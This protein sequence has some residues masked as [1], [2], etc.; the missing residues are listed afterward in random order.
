MFDLLIKNGQVV[1]GSGAN[2]FQADVAVNADKVVHVGGLEIAEAATVID[3]AGQVVTPGFIDVHSHGD[4]TLP[5]C[6]TA[7]SLIHQ[8]VTTAVVGQCGISLAPLLTA[9][10]EEVIAS[11]ETR[12]MPVPWE[13]WSDFRSYLKFMSELGIAVN[14][15]PLVGQGTVRAAVMSFA[16]GRANMNQM[17]GMRAEV[18]KAMEAGAVGIST[19]LVY[20]PGSYAST[21]ELIELVKV[22]GE[23]HGLY[24]SH[25]RGEDHVLLDAVAEALRIGRETGAAVHI[26]HLKAAWPVNWD[27]QG[28]AIEMIEQARRE[29][30]DVSADVYPYLA[31]AT[32]LK[33]VL[34]EWA[35][36]GGKDTIL[37]RL[38]EPDSRKKIIR[39]MSQDGFCRDGSWDLVLISHS[40]SRPDY[41]GRYVS[42]LAA[43]ARRTPEEWIMDALLETD[44]DPGMVLFMIREENLKVLLRHEA[45]MIGSD[46]FTIPAS[47]RLAQGFP[48][49][50]TFGTFPRVL[51][52]Y[53]R[54]E[55]ILTLE[56]AIH[57]MTGSPAAKLRLGDRGQIKTGFKADLVVLDPRIVSDRATYEKPFQYPTGIS[58]VFCNGTAVI[59]EGRPTGALPGRVLGHT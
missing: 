35:Q 33:T 20:P 58:Y 13:R 23:R 41:A 5:A 17:A 24:F 2:A 56:K 50:R 59:S 26:C 7:D 3:A 4:F 42:D 40:K 28:Y 51:G 21:E 38:K 44:L 39:S 55:K 54:E 52:R 46:S 43:E 15:V 8:G 25:I 1:D 48:H 47:G 11:L 31:G 22:A 53:V 37:R 19:G 6:P 14:I 57:K 16:S 30:L 12:K 27:K 45:V 36:E 29:G 18:I 34:P 10:R 49:P 32:S 9:T